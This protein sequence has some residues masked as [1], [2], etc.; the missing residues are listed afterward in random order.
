[1]YLSEVVFIDYNVSSDILIT[2]KVVIIKRF[3]MLCRITLKLLY[4]F[5]FANS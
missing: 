1:M 2:N 5:T 3:S 4:L